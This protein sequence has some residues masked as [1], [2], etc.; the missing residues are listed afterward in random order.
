MLLM[1]QV[2]FLVY[3]LEKPSVFKDAFAMVV[4]N[5]NSGL[6][7]SPHAVKMVVLN[8]HSSNWKI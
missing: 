3:N 1:R 6:L 8:Y 2:Y 7:C 5:S 4:K